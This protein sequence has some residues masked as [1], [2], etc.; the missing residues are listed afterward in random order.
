MKILQVING[1]ATA[2]A[3]KLLIDT[4]PIY[5]KKAVSMDLLVFDG[6]SYPFM[7]ALEEEKCCT[8]ISLG[9]GSVYNPLHIFKIIKFF[10]KYDIFHVHLFPALYWVVIAKLI[11]FSSI[12]IIFTEHSTSNRRMQNPILRVFDYFIYSKIDKIISISEAVDIKI[13]QHINLPENKF[14]LIQNGVNLLKISLETPYFKSDLGL[15]LSED[16]IILIQVSR[17]QLGKDQATLIKSL[18]YLPENVQLLLVGVG[19]LVK[20][21]EELVQ[22]LN[23]TGRVHFLGTRMDVLKL[24]KT[25]DIIV[26]STDY[27]GLSLSSIEGLAS[28]K[29]FVA[30]DVPGLSEIVNGA[31]ILFP[32]QDEKALAVVINKLIDDKEHYNKTVT[33]CLSRAKEYDIEIMIGKHLELYQSISE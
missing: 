32:S 6:T 9:N 33:E 29:P 25:V 18:K 7:K 11:S 16:N 3:E 5:N 28:G 2:G 30:S 13:K 17:F 12:K 4:I 31:G 8:I 26:L 23:L 19:D 22:N 1:L 21:N 27:E 14:E 24:L 20:S 15:R 10:K